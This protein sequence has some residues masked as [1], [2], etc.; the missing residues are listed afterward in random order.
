MNFIPESWIKPRFS[1]GQI[2]RLTWETDEEARVISGM[3]YRVFATGP[4][5]IYC[6]LI[7]GDSEW[8]DEDQFVAV[9]L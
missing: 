4:S 2:V 5:W 3:R 1:F 9:Y 8:Y 6:I 7:N